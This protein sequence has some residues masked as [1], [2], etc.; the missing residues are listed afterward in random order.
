MQFWGGQISEKCIL[1][2]ENLKVD[3][4]VHIHAKLSTNFYYHRQNFPSNFYHHFPGKGNYLS[5]FWSSIQGLNRAIYKKFILQ[6]MTLLLYL[7]VVIYPNINMQNIQDSS[8]V[9]FAK[10]N[11]RKWVKNQRKM[12]VINIKCFVN[13][14][15]FAV[16]FREKCIWSC[17]CGKVTG[18]Y[19]CNLYGC[20]SWAQVHDLP[21]SHW[22]IGTWRAQCL[23]FWLHIY[24]F[25]QCNTSYKSIHLLGAHCMS[26]WLHI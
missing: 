14:L 22:W 26:F 10:E 24:I 25:T 2:V 5:P 4:N 12:K 15:F 21:C 1:W 19:E 7:Q 20:T 23:S 11:Q 9:F 6:D 18:H 3:I 17:S 16:N 8:G 13:T